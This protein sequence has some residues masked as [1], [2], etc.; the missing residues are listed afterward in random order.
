[1]EYNVWTYFVGSIDDAQE[2]ANEWNEITG[3]NKFRVSEDEY[4]NGTHLIEGEI[5]RWVR[6]Q[7]AIEM[8]FMIEE[9]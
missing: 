6:N 8:D 1:M 7:T 2:I 4:S 9:L 5:E 3:T